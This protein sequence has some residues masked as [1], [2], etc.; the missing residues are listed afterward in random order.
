MSRNP[1][2]FFC[3]TREKDTLTEMLQRQQV[4]MPGEALALKDLEARGVARRERMRRSWRQR[5]QRL[6]YDITQFG[7]DDANSGSWDPRDTDV[8]RGMKPAKRR[9]FEKRIEKLAKEYLP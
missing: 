9:Q 5:M 2:H 7:R 1:G 6:I 4:I 8:F 3:G